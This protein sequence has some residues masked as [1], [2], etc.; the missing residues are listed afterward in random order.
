MVKNPSEPC[1]VKGKC[2]SESY[3]EVKPEPGKT[4]DSWDALL[5][6]YRDSELRHWKKRWIFR[7]HRDISWCL[8]TSLERAIRRQIGPLGIRAAKWEY[9]LE[10]YFRRIAPMYLPDAPN[11]DNWIEWRALIRHYGG[12]TR[13]LDWTYSFFVAVFLAMQQTKDHEHCTVWACNVDWW[14]KCV[15]RRLPRLGKIV[16]AKNSKSETEFNYL[17]NLKRT[18]GIWPVNPF[19]LNERLHAQQGVFLMPLDVSGSFMENLRD[20]A[21]PTVGRKHLW[22]INLSCNKTFRKECAA[23][24]Q[25]MNIQNENLFPGLEGLA[26]D[27]ENEMLMPEHFKGIEPKP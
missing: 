13:L 9:K 3:Y 21:K 22:K 23:E 1:C 26:R 20:L 7:G 14:K 27:L 11:E 10:R 24:L 5:T 16:K 25:R 18:K 2:C 8:E 12:P 17:G 15:V 19:R 6:F 4:I